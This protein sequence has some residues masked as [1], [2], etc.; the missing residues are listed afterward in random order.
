[1]K[2]RAFFGGFAWHHGAID[3]KWH[4]TRVHV[5]RVFFDD[6]TADTRAARAQSI[7]GRQSQ[8]LAA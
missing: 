2:R 6:A 4:D 7:R 3:H 1:V 5:F 8:S